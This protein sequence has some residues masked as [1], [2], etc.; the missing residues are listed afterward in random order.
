[1]NHGIPFDRRQEV[2]YGCLAE[3]RMYQTIEQGQPDTAFM[4]DGDQ[5]RIEMLDDTCHS[6]FGAIVQQ[7]ESLEI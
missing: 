3:L 4:I 7:V 1:M 6:L 2:G 5:V